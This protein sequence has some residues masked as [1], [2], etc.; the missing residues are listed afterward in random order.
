LFLYMKTTWLLIL[1]LLNFLQSLFFS[2][3]F[4]C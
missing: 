4:V 2:Y 1:Q 3:V